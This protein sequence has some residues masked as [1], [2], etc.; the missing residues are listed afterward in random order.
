MMGRSRGRGWASR[1]GIAPPGLG[2]NS[3]PFMGR[4]RRSRRR[5]WASRLGIAPP[6][7]GK[8]SPHHG[9]RPAEGLGLTIGNWLAWVRKK[10]LPIHGEVLAKP[11][12]GLGLAIGNCP[13]WVRKKLPASWGEAGGGAEPHDWE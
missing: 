7:L 1:L 11:A 3:S 5:G 2:K 13:A 8:N 12:E 9:A 4:C 10:L 6:G